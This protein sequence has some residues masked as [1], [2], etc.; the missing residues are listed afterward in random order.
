MAV[1]TQAI[2]GLTLQVMGNLVD[3][4]TPGAAGRVLRLT[5]QS[6]ALA[7]PAPPPHPRRGLTRRSITPARRR[8]PERPQ[9]SRL[10][11]TRRR[12]TCPT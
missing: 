7:D 10:F 1:G 8:H 12:S 9:P 6:L 3:N 5:D 11:I 4:E 2:A